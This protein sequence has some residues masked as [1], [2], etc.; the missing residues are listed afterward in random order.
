[1]R[2]AVYQ[3]EDGLKDGGKLF[4]FGPG[5]VNAV[6]GAVTAEMMP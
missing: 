6:Q 4:I 3:F 2:I 5:W 1:M